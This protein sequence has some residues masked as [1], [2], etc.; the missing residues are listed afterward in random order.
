MK[1]IIGTIFMIELFDVQ[2]IIQLV[3]NLQAETFKVLKTINDFSRKHLVSRVNHTIS[4]SEHLRIQH[5]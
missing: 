4:K 3:L 1:H 2:N 5:R